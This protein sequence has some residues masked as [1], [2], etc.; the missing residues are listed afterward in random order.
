[1]RRYVLSKDA[2]IEESQMVTTMYPL[3]DAV[4]MEAVNVHNRSQKSCAGMVIVIHHF[5]VRIG[6]PCLLA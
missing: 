6:Y 2:I 1:M 5:T 3:F 4:G